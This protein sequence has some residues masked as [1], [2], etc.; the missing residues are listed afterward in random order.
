M[1]DEQA[2]PVA[3][4]TARAEQAAGSMAEQANQMAGEVREQAARGAESGKERAADRLDHVAEAVHRSADALHGREDWLATLVDRGAD[5]LSAFAD[6]LRRNDLRG[7]LARVEQM[8]RRQPAL[9]IGASMAAGFALVRL[10]RAG[11]ERSDVAGRWR[12]YG[13]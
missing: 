11:M 5:G 2:R 7:T 4:A 8:A 13:S 12:G 10:G 9:L 3:G 1:S 6:S